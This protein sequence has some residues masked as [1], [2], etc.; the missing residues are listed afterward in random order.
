MV[1]YYFKGHISVLITTYLV[2]K[3]YFQNFLVTIIGIKSNFYGKNIHPVCCA[4][5]ATVIA[6]VHFVIVSILLDKN[7]DLL[8]G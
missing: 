1:Q 7:L 4:H 3:I 5:I 6:K 2:K 8:A